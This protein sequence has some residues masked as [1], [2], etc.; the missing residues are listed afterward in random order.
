[1][2]CLVPQRRVE[3]GNVASKL[4][5]HVNAETLPILRTMRN[6][7]DI[8]GKGYYHVELQALTSS[9]EMCPRLDGRIKMEIFFVM[10]FQNKVY[11]V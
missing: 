7:D 5:W 10:S 4:G 1:M 6:R 2:V 9:Y 8:S 11:V 3:S